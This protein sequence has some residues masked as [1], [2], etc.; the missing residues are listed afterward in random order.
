MLTESKFQ[1]DGDRLGCVAQSPFQVSEIIKRD[2]VIFAKRPTFICALHKS[3]FSW[4]QFCTRVVSFPI[5][6]YGPPA[7]HLPQ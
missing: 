1:L 7:P 2:E 6:H 3:L 5:T 4:L